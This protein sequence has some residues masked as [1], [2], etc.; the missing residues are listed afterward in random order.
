LRSV[1]ISF[2]ALVLLQMLGAPVSSQEDPVVLRGLRHTSHGRDQATTAIGQVNSLL[3]KS[4]LRF[5]GSWTATPPIRETSDIPVYLI[6]SPALSASTPAAV[7]RGC[8]C[9]F[10]NASLLKSFMDQHTKGPGRFELDAASL[11]TFMLLHEAGHIRSNSAGVEFDQGEMSQLNIEPSRAKASE[12]DADEFAAMLIREHAQP[13]GD[14]TTFLAAHE[15]AMQLSKLSWNMQAYR[16]LDEFGA[17]ATGKRSVFFDLN[18][19][20]PNLAWRILRSNYLI[21]RTTET[22]QL[23]DSFEEIRQ[24][25]LS[26]EPLYRR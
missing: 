16:T 7:P 19:S 5:R 10:V 15:V 24:R 14:V 8:R 9:V 11:L 6:E 21:Q 17:A 22:K 25:G 1:S 18:Y 23:L 20:H 13:G 3:S 26:P 4:D 2:R 12:E